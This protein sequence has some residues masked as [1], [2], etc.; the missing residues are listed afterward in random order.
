MNKKEKKELIK[1]V[2]QEAEKLK[3]QITPEETSNLDFYSLRAFNDSRC[4]Y[5]QMTGNCRTKRAIELI[6]KCC[7]KT[8][9]TEVYSTRDPDFGNE[10]NGPPEEC[11]G[12]PGG[13][14]LQYCSPIELF[15]TFPE[16]RKNGNNK[17]L[18]LYLKGKKEE[19]K[20]I[21]F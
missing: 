15:I 7:F 21:S 6:T 19:L 2:I 4:I 17:S 14:A 20:L 12:V 5:G 16:N 9:K 13:V 18:V 10:L 11:I 3:K 8:Y 1:L